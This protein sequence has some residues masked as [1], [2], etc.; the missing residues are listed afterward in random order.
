MDP[1]TPVGEGPR[2]FSPPGGMADGWHGPQMPAGRDV[3]VP[4][5]WSSA[6]NDG[7]GGDRGI[8]LPPPEHGCT[9]NFDL[10]YHG[11]M[12][13]GVAESGNA[14]LQEMVGTS[15]SGYHE[16]QDRTCIHRGEGGDGGRRTG[17]GG[18]GRVGE[19]Q[20]KEI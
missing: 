14:P 10:S 7:T 12:F 17:V 6:E 18:R 5:H 1:D 15:C 19:G 20:T 16:D 13:G 8:Y 9:I 4:I 11:L 3:G 2:G